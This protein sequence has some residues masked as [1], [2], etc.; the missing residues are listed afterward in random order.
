MYF[1]Y[2]DYTVNKKI[3]A[4]R[5]IKNLGVRNKGHPKKEQC[6]ELVFGH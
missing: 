3:G 6:L 4:L 5:A 2:I 1:H